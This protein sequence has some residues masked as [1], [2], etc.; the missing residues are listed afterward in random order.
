[1]RLHP[2]VQARL[3]SRSS[4]ADGRQAE[5]RCARSPRVGPG[6]ACVPGRTA[7]AGG[8][9]VSEPSPRLSAMAARRRGTAA[10]Y[11]CAEC[12][13]TTVKWVGR[14]GE[15]QAWGTVA[16]V[17]AAART[18]AATVVERPAAA[19]RRGRRHARRGAQH[20]GRRAGPGARRRAGARRG[21]PRRRRAGHRQVD[22]AA[23]RRGPAPRPA[24]RR[25]P[26]STSA[27]RSRRRRCG[28]GPSG[29]RRWR[30]ACSSRPRPT[31]PRCWARSRR[32][33][34]TSSS[35]TRCRPSQRRG[36]GL[37]R[38]RHARSAR[39]RPPSSRRPR[40]ATSPTLLVGHVTKDGSIAGPRVLEHLVDVVV[41]V[42]GRP[43]LP[44]AAGPGGEE[45][46]RADRRGGLLRPVRRRHRRA[47]RPERAVPVRPRRRRR[48]HL[49]HRHAG[50][51]A[52][53][54]RRGAGARRADQPGHP[55]PG[56]ERPRREPGRR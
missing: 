12:G 39:S 36:R 23:R 34:P 1:M 54:R 48:R 35:S 41:P 53:A 42:R 11:R 46:L 45:P 51:P 5:H 55:A 13:W 14:C 22:A 32:C 47:G 28:C 2:E 33:S 43:A 10:A 9:A 44:A 6:A 31:W 19:D 20:R 37:G 27:V 26:C 49:R 30:A 8:T 56:H 3:T 29:S 52:A 21:G 18:T 7:A 50:G 25:R 16:E 4:P 24:A 17:G 38:Q 15:C 40:R